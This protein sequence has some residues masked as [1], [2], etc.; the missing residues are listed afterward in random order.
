MIVALSG[1]V[2]SAVLLSLALEALGREGVLAVTGS[3]PSLSENDLEDARSVARSLGARHE[4]VETRELERPGYRANA[5]ERCYHC[6][7][8]LFEVLGALARRR[9]FAA[10]AY[11]AIW[12]DQEALRPGMRA[13]REGGVLAPLR[14]AGLTKAEVRA[15]AAELGLQVAAKPAGACLASRIPVGTAVTPERL[16]R[17]GRAEHGLRKLGFRQLRVRD[18]GD[19]ARIEVAPEEIDR[20][21]SP[22]IRTLAT[23]AVREAGFRYVA[24]DLDGYRTGALDPPPRDRPDEPR[25]PRER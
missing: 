15:L 22:A 14:E 1:G 23:A 2:D 4:V 16:S 25:E 10:V 19:V 24:V 13:A 9:G 21:L 8:E 6:R 11:G 12:D 7:S 5:G 20:L 3:S 18:H 17:V